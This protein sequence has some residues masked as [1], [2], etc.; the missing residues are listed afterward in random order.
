MKVEDFVRVSPNE[1]GVVLFIQSPQ[2]T[3][4]GSVENPYKEVPFDKEA[5]VQA[6][7]KVLDRFGLTEV[8]RVPVSSLSLLDNP[9]STTAPSVFKE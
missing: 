8:L 2:V 3:G 5:N 4:D 7:V 6:D 9:S 1:I